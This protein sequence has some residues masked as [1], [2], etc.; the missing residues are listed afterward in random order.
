MRLI[1]VLTA[2]L[3]MAGVP[4]YGA[5]T[6]VA[7][8]EGLK[9][10]AMQT[11]IGI[12]ANHPGC[13]LFLESRRDCG[14]ASEFIEKLK[15]V[16]SGRP[17]ITSSDVFEAAA[18]AVDNDPE[19]TNA[20]RAIKS[21][22][23]RQGGNSI[24][25][26]VNES[27]NEAWAFKGPWVYEGP[28]VNGQ[29]HGVGIIIDGEGRL[30]RGEF[31]AGRQVGKGEYIDTGKS[32]RRD[33]GDSQ[34]FDLNG[35]GIRHTPQTRV[36]GHFKADRPHGR[37]TQVSTNGGRYEGDYVNGKK[38]GRGTTVYTNGQRYEGTYVDGKRHGK[39]TYTFPSG[40]RYQGE[41]AND[42]YHGQGTLLLPSGARYVGSHVDDKRF[43]GRLT[44]ANGMVLAVYVDGQKQGSGAPPVNATQQAVDDRQQAA[45][46]EQERKEARRRDRR[47]ALGVLRTYSD[48]TAS[49]GNNKPA[50]RLSRLE[51]LAQK[52]PKGETRASTAL[53]RYADNLNRKVS[54]NTGSNPGSASTSPGPS[55]QQTGV[56]REGHN[57][58]NDANK[59]V[60]RSTLEVYSPA[61]GV[62]RP[63]FKYVN[64]CPYDLSVAIIPGGNLK[65]A[66]TFPTG[67][68][69]APRSYSWAPWYERQDESPVIFACRA[70]TL[71]LNSSAGTVGCR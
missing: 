39:G 56:T 5:D 45:A 29:R 61:T 40:E 66:R 24:S 52:P 11:Q 63:M 51:T 2:L 36:V 18:P 64:N 7:N 41:F 8:C 4:A 10:P 12:C 71:A 59:C 6:W 48:T 35:S 47:E 38:H 26:G 68:R 43:N 27:R 70:G 23:D 57:P 34:G 31:V 13:R 16:T 25:T 69:S 53:N 28:M 58:E 60:E 32:K 19:F 9:N 1:G 17:T 37:V 15:V 67:G 22:F 30:F 49:M 62:K 44:D 42:N 21:R 46:A 20:S 50:N 14:T 54:N 33:V 55:S 65:R 3:V